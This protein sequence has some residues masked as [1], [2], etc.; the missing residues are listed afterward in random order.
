MI[1]PAVEDL[2]S[3]ALSEDVGLRDLTTEAI[4]E[5]GRRALGTIEQK[6]PG[7]VFGLEVAHVVFRQLDSL[8]RWRVREP[9]GEWR[10]EVPVVVAELEGDAHALLSGERVALNFLQHLSGVAT[11]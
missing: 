8:V 2:V 11:F 9:E 7:M 1:D 3:R 6:G 5:P 4:V 10:D